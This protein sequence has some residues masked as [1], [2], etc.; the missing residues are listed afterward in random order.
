M[1]YL[2]IDY[3]DS[4]VG[5][6]VGD[7]ESRFALPLETIPNKGFDQLTID[8]K[9]FIASEGIDA[10]VIG[11]PTLGATFGGQRLKIEAVIEE[12]RSCI[13]I[14]IHINDESFSSRQAQQLMRDKS[15]A[16]QTDEH[17]IAAMLILQSFFDKKANG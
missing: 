10:L 12:F 5:L 9:R 2:G 13:A 11:V 1:R 15:S 7:D 8:L 6:A 3:G 4:H 14:P 16:P 17:A